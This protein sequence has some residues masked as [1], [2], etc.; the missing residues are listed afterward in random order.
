MKHIFTLLFCLTI[1]SVAWSQQSITINSK[2]KMTG[3]YL[4]QNIKSLKIDTLNFVN[5]KATIKTK[6]TEVTPFAFART[7]PQAF[8]LF[9]ADPN[10]NTT[11]D[12]DG[13]NIKLNNITGSPSTKKYLDFLNNQ[14]ILQTTAQALQ[15][16]Y[17]KPDINKD[18]VGQVFSFI[19]LQLNNIF[20]K[21]ITDNKNS[22]MSSYM[23]YDV[24]NRNR[25]IKPNELKEL[26]DILGT[27][28]KATHF[29]KLMSQQMV[30][31]SAMELDNI[32]PDFTLK[33]RNGKTHS[34]KKLRG[35]YVLLDFWA[36]WCGPCVKEIP[37]L[38][39]AYAQYKDKGFEIMSVSIDRKPEQWKKALDKYKMAWIHVIDNEDPKQKVTQNLYYVP[40][41][42]R[43]V[44][45]D[46]T[47]KVIG[48]DFRGNALEKKLEEI[49]K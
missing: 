16:E 29:G 40:S 12:I 23:L 33:D 26:Y 3:T 9:F 45:L 32:A 27:E 13:E 18:S 10:K 7:N 44:L 11:I 38:K 34:L 24:A 14:S 2:S 5:G 39:T 30:K 47:G 8:F 6:L 37:N 35:K 25:N 48:K 41:I 49:F 15:K 21:F 19:N 36:S 46:K 22:N 20:K 1:T 43:T 31:S 4:L 28:G 17:A 42:P